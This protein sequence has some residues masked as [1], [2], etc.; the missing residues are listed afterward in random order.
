MVHSGGASL[1]SKEVMEE[2][3]FEQ[4]TQLYRALKEVHFSGKKK[5]QK[6]NQEASTLCRQNII[7][8]A[9]PKTSSLIGSLLSRKIAA[10]IL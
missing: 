9:L 3:H 4:Y 5:R 8:H 6:T 7:S 2:E 10:M 1:E